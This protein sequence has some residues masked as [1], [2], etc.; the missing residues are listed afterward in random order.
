MLYRI[1]SKLSTPRGAVYKQGTISSLPGISQKGITMLLDKQL[2]TEVMAPPLEVLPGWEERAENLKD[3]GIVTAT[4]LIE[5]DLIE[6]SSR[7]KYTVKE[8]EVMVLEVMEFI[9]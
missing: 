6:L 3:L 1:H 2:I 5:S 4:Q 8:L 9:S 7:L